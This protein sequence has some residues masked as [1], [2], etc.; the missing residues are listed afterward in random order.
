MDH[1]RAPVLEAIKAFKDRGDVVYGPPGH[2]HGRGVDQRVID[3]LGRDAF[4][5]AVISLNGFDDRGETHQVIPRA[6]A[7]MADAVGAEHA[8]FSTC[9][10][11]LS[12]KSAM[13][14]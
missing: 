4:R 2:K 14:S 6:E 5:S 13:I 9:G 10:S 8:F 12:V 3:L 7:L 1:S 11:S